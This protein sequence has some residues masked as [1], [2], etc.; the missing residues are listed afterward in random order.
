MQSEETQRRGRLAI[1]VLGS[2]NDS[3]GVLLPTALA[4]MNEAVH[5]Y[6]SSPESVL[7]LTGGFGSFNAT[8]KPHAEYLKAFAIS[9]LVPA[10]DILLCP[11]SSHTV[12]DATHSLGMLVKRQVISRVIV[13]TSDFHVERARLIFNAVYHDVLV[14]F[15]GVTAPMSSGSLEKARQ[16]EAK[17]LERL[18]GQEGV[19]LGWSTSDQA[20]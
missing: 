2:P 11:L 13:V 8:E 7:V 20:T 12:D 14:D 3:S 5:L 1:I 19:L 9:H 17:A 15:V 10:E 4:R 6:F 16:H 18:Q